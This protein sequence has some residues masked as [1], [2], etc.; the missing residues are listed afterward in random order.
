[1]TPKKRSPHRANGE[2]KTN[3]DDAPKLAP[4]RAPVKPKPVEWWAL[5]CQLAQAHLKLAQEGLLA[6]K[7]IQ[8]LKSFM[9]R[10][11]G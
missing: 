8:A 4:A 9:G 7:E 10:T 1:M 3:L 11:L 2:G 5:E 6:A